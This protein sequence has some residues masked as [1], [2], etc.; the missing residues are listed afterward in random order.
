M[1]EAGGGGGE[2][3][4]EVVAVVVVEERELEVSI[5]T[6]TE[7]NSTHQSAQRLADVVALGPRLAALEPGF[8]VVGGTRRARSQRP[9]LLQG[10]SEITLVQGLVLKNPCVGDQ[11]PLSSGTG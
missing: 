3:E 2:E 11:D 1:E 6:Q 7:K 8:R 10:S 5:H 9:F 4:E